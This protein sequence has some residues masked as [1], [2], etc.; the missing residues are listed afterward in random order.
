MALLKKHQTPLRFLQKIRNNF[1]LFY[2][3]S[4]LHFSPLEMFVCL[5]IYLG[6][7]IVGFN[8]EVFC[9]LGH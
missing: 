1:A 4:L 3:N 9:R 7:Y 2:C 5:F 6:N 8:T